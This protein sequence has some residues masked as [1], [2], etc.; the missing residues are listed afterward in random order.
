MNERTSQDEGG[1]RGSPL[2]I[3]VAGRLAGHCRRHYAAWSHALPFLAWLALMGGLD[4]PVFGPPHPWKYAV[5]TFVCLALFLYFRPWRW[6]PALAWRNMVW[7][8]LVG[9]GVF[10]V[11][12]YPAVP[13]GGQY[14]GWQ[15]WY[16]RF[17][18]LPLGR[19]PDPESGMIYDPSLAGWPMAL[20][21]LAG[22][23]FVI[24][25]IEEF[26]W[27]GFLYRWLIDRNFLRVSLNRVDWEAVGIVCLLFG[28]AHMEWLVGI[29]TGF[30]Y[31]W[32]MIKTRDV[33]AVAVAHVITNL[34]LGIY[35]LVNGA[36][37]FW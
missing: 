21:R 10:V 26:F 35:V 7:A 24:A 16:V 12:T 31:L 8:V 22:S 29:A 9:I 27:R 4:L 2:R 36:Y 25:V 14:T 3:S 32:L 20:I 17:G 11:W 1:E 6:Y 30:V 37:I 13:W 15:E 23:A 5:R 19:L 34:L 33:W 28:L 18:I